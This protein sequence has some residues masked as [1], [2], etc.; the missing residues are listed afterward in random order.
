MNPC[1]ILCSGSGI[2][3]AEDGVTEIPCPLCEEYDY[4]DCD[5]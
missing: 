1:C 5:E 2:L 4:G 3:M